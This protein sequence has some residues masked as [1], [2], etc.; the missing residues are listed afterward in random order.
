MPRV[1]SPQCPAESCSMRLLTRCNW[2][3]R[4]V[5]LHHFHRNNLASTLH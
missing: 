4:H 2:P 5:G 3:A 1:S